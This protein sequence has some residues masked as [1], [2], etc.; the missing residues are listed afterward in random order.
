LAGYTF[1]HNFGLN[2]NALHPIFQFANFHF[3]SPHFSN[4][5]A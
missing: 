1:L 4:V 2:I 3:L 5:N